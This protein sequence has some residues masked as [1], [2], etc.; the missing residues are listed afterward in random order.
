MVSE[1]DNDVGFEIDDEFAEP[2]ESVIVKV[3]VCVWIRYD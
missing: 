3:R 2:V 1:I